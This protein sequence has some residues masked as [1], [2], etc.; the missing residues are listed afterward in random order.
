MEYNIDGQNYTE[1]ELKNMINFY[2]NVNTLPMDTKQEI[3]K[4]LPYYRTLNTSLYK[5]TQAYDERFCSQP[6]SFKEFNNYIL[7]EKNPNA[8]L[9]TP[10]EN[11]LCVIK[12]NNLDNVYVYRFRIVNH[13]WMVGMFSISYINFKKDINVY[14][15]DN[16]Y[17]D[18]INS[19][20]IY[21]ARDCQRGNYIEN[22]LLKD[23][24]Q[25]ADIP[26]V[27]VKK[28][29]YNIEKYIYHSVSTGNA[30][31]LNDLSIIDEF[32]FDRNGLPN[33]NINYQAYDLDYAEYKK[34]LLQQI[35]FL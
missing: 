30:F 5:D 23:I 18:M 4:Y 26:T 28:F 25:F 15:N 13:K 31:N 16:T 33:K 12:I 11:E 1:E 17:Y 22:Q 6:I 21:Q 29:L 32:T 20:Y 35:K 8:Y 7:K 2:N 34:S 14:I 24:Q 3:V 27:D 19:Y 9:F 10:K